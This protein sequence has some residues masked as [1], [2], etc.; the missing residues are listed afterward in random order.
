MADEY[1]LDDNGEPKLDADGNKILK[2]PANKIEIPKGVDPDL[3]KRLVQEGIDE[4]LNPV[5]ENL[6]SAYAARDEALQ[7]VAKYEQEKRDAEVARLKE[8]GEFKKAHE[9]EMSQAKAREEALKKRNIEL[10]RDVDLRRAL[11]TTEFR[12]ENAAEMAYKDIVSG[13]V[14][15]EQ[16][17]WVHKTGASIQD[18]TKSFLSD[19]ANAF[20]LKQKVSTG[21]G[22]TTITPGSAD[23]E[24]KSLFK[25]S[26]AEVLQRAAEGKLPTQK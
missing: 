15:N 9:L 7:A 23:D 26:Q 13:L 14:Q 2:T 5:K 21:A 16:G 10:T 24:P 8:E 17:D 22:S 19:E 20:L 3:I 18:Y 12:S 4:A 6:N 1:V 25:M 11:S